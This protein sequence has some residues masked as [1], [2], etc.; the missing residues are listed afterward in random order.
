MAAGVRDLG[1]TQLGRETVKGT[2]VAATTRW[3]GQTTLTP[4]EPRLP[5]N[6]QNGLLLANKA[7][8]PIAAKHLDFSLEAD[9]TF[10]QLLHVLN[11]NFMGLTTGTG[12][13]AD[14]TW[15]FNP[16]FTAD[17]GL[18]AFTLQ[19]RMTDGSTNWDERV[20]YAMGRSFEIT[21]AYG[22]NAKLTMEG[23]GRPIELATA[24]TGAI[25]VPAVNF[26]PTSL[27]KVYIDDTAGGLGGTQ[28]LG[29]LYGFKWHFDSM[30]Q[31]K[32]YLDGRADLSFSSH[33]IKAANFTLELQGEFQA[34]LATEQTKARSAAKRFVR[35]EAVGAALGGSNYKITIDL[36]C[37][38]E[39]GVF[40]SDGDRDGNDAVTLKYIQDYDTATPLAAKV[41]VVNA[42]AALP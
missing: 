33:G 23:F 11:M 5:P 25:S 30:A 21:G 39:Q 7:S 24:I 2:A 14:K 3:V 42:L 37:G 32:D 18:N 17:P 38:Y 29:T 19:K 10:E 40:D 20:A 34:Q 9:L 27:F 4:D 1:V 41:V 35:L 31:P 16:T 13:G 36:C 26:V 6:I 8:P 28:M 22:E 15:T 12:A